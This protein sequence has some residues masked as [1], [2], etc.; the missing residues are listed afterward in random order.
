M[1]I[2]VT[3][4]DKIAVGDGTRIVCG[5]SDYVVRFD[6]DAEWEQF[7]TRTMIVVN[8]DKTYRE[9][10]FTGDTVALP[11]I[12]N[13]TGISIGLYA[14]DLHT[15][16]SASFDCLKSA[17]CG[18]GVHEEPNED[19][20]N[21]LVQLVQNG[22]VKGEKGDKGE[23]GIQG[24]QGE[25]G[26]KG[27]KGDKGDVGLQ[28]IQGQRGEKGEKGDKGDSGYT[29]VKGVDY[30]DG[31]DGKDAVIDA[32]LTQSGQAADAKITGD[33]I[34]ELKDDLAD[35]APAGAS[36]GQLFRVASVS[37]DG[38][39]IMEPVDMPSSVDVQI[40]GASIVKD[41]VANIPVAR[42]AAGL[43]VISILSSWNT[44]TA[45]DG[46]LSSVV[47]PYD[48]L[49]TQNGGSFI[50]KGT[51]FNVIDAILLRTD[52]EQTLSAAQKEQARQNIGIHTVTQAEYD[53]LTDT[54][55]IYI[56]VEG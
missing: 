2:K 8:N 10:V 1:E 11:V 24:V 32:T 43:G 47:R 19:V 31:K 27:D 26:E 53:A 42:N 6:L 28:G 36:V 13:Q 50:S 40:N 34:V 55:G 18:L 25:K 20:Y 23:Q 29:P 41:G 56:I 45:G 33:K 12:N 7:I 54:N 30:F 21:Q 46:C 5:N 39:Y 3:V 22:A 15:T 49:K 4:R 37:D 51:L 9:Y 38:K 52:A 17:R 48:T 16:T 35:L 44:T 14:G